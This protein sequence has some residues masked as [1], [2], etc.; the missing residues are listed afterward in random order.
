MITDTLHGFINADGTLQVESND[1]GLR[2]LLKHS[3][4]FDEGR[5]LETYFTEYYVKEGF[6]WQKTLNSANY[7]SVDVFL[8]ALRNVD[9]FSKAIQDIERQKKGGGLAGSR[10]V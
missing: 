9:N 2:I 6:G 10:Y 4:V 8:E 5:Q 3:I 1:H 7:A